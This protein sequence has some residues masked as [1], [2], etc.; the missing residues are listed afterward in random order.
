MRTSRRERPTRERQHIDR[1]LADY[2]RELHPLASTPGERA[3]ATR[4]L[5]GLGWVVLGSRTGMEALRQGAI[6]RLTWADMSLANA[7]RLVDAAWRDEREVH[8]S[9][10]WL[11]QMSPEERARF[12]APAGRG[13]R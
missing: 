11:D 1:L 2:E 13:G 9:G 8:R 7:T 6:E 3:A 5:A 12:E 4:E 10:Y